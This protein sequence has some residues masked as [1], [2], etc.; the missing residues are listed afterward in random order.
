MACIML[1][2]ANLEGAENSWLMSLTWKDFVTAAAPQQWYC[3]VYWVITTVNMGGMGTTEGCRSKDRKDRKE[4]SFPIGSLLGH[5]HGEEW[6]AMGSGMGTKGVQ[7][8]GKDRKEVF[9]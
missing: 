7:V 2:I 1:M 9:P 4:G 3:A 6:E 8:N 5:H